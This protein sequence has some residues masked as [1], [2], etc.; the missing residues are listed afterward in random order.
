VIAEASVRERRKRQ[1]RQE[2]GRRRERKQ[3][4]RE[5][6]RLWVL[7]PDGSLAADIA[8]RRDW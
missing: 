8:R 7:A 3:K 6:G 5:E 4:R 2:R 1:Q